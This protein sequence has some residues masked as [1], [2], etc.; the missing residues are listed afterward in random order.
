ML[1]KKSFPLLRLPALL[2]ISIFTTVLLTVFSLL[3]LV[4]HFTFNYAQKEAEQRLQQL[5]WQMRDSLDLV[6]QKAVGDVQLLSNLSQVKDA[7]DLAETR[8]LLNNLQKTF[9]SYAWIGLADPKGSVLVAT[10]GLLEN[11]DVSQRPWFKNGQ[12]SLYTGDYHP[13]LLLEKKLPY[14]VE[15]WRFVDVSIPITN[16]NGTY[17]GVMGVHLSWAWARET[18]HKLLAPVDSQ[19]AVDI[20]IIREDGA[21]I[22]GPKSMEETKLSPGILAHI[23]S[24]VTGTTSERWADGKDY[25]IGYAQTGQSK[26]YPSLN[27]TVLVRQ[28]ESLALANSYQLQKNILLL[29]GLLGLMMAALASF[30][31]RRLSKPLNLLSSAIEARATNQLTTSI[32]IVYGFHEAHLLSVTLSEM[33]IA[34]ENS[35]L[36]LLDINEKLEST[37]EIR[38]REIARKA[39]ELEQ[40]LL[41]QQSA[42]NRLQAIA[43]NLPSII[44]YID[45]NE[46]HVFV[47]AYISTMYDAQPEELLGKTLREVN[48]EERYAEFSPHIKAALGG[49]AVSFESNRIVSGI[50]HSYQFNYI[51]A[52]NQAGDVEGFYAMTFD[53]TERRKIELMKSE[54][55]ATVSH[56][57]RTPLTSINGALRLIGAGL[58][59]ALTEKA[60]DLIAIASRNSE[61]LL[62][63]INDIL[64]IEKIESGSMEFELR[65]T[66]LQPVLQ[67]SIAASSSFAEQYGVTLHL[68]PD[69]SDQQNS[70]INVDKDRLTQIVINLISNAIKFSSTGGSVSVSLSS[71]N[72][73][74]RIAVSDQGCGIPK[75]FYNK[76]FQK[77]SQVDGSNIKKKGGTGLGLSICKTMVEQMQ[78]KIGFESEVGVGSMFYVE[79]PVI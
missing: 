49:E 18:A 20:L 42:Q 17:R 33:V 4:S 28:S 6:M 11:H 57:L 34:Q 46:R 63:L 66:E 27:W 64:D 68:Q 25:L 62:R 73:I 65:P 12:K 50:P 14:S 3:L 75:D 52:K 36:A 1:I 30:L 41:K 9:P 31:S 45:A 61:R 8:K 32:P 71:V 16:S 5:A 7:R 15:P 48:G 23:K 19:Y 59:G 60:K 72:G 2:T 47:N 13:A 43:D 38:T 40:S 54:F 67:D 69:S 35:R 39:Q 21:V 55:V 77:F 10:Q 44:T 26:N 24:K 29:G 51:P 79:F 70:M 22:L 53:I 76:I 37:V 56:E 74:A 78:G 58:A